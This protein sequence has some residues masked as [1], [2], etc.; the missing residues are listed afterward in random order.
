MQCAREIEVDH[1]DEEQ[2]LGVGETQV[3]ALRSARREPILAVACYARLLLAAGRRYGPYAARAD[4]PLPKWRRDT[5]T[6]C[7]RYVR[8][9][10][11]MHSRRSK[12]ISP[13]RMKSDAS[14][15]E[16]MYGG[17]PMRCQGFLPAL[18]LTWLP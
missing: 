17:A 1:R 2:L 4:L 14:S 15:D 6:C 13:T 16:A 5:P 9:C 7:D 18:L 11:Q 10:G 8:T 3:R 12:E